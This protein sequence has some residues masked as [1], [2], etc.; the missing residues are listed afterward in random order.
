MKLTKNVLTGMV[1][2]EIKK[3]SSD[4]KTNFLRQQI[5]KMIVEADD[6]TNV[7][8]SLGSVMKKIADNLGITDNASIAKLSLAVKK[9]LKGD[10]LDLEEKNVVVDVFMK[11]MLA[12][13]A[14][15]QEIFNALRTI[16]KEDSKIE[17]ETT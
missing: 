13:S 8:G 2:Q 11:M 17:P 16:A 4:S 14:D 1:L 12:D 5:R 10:S 9:S 15:K 7:K 6:A 3:A